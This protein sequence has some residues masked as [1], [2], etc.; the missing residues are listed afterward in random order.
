MTMRRS[1]Q[2]AVVLVI[3][4]AAV[5]VSAQ[6]RIPAGPPAN[7]PTFDV[8][9]IKRVTD[10]RDRRSVGEQPGGRFVLSGMAIAPAIR[11]A[12]PADISELI[13]A[14]DWV[15]SETYDLTAQAGREVPKEQMEAMLRAML[16]DKFKLEV[17]YEIQE[18]PVYALVLA[19]ADG[20]LG[21]DIKKS[22]L[23]CDA[24]QAA[25]RAG[26]KETYPVTSN[27]APACGMS[28]LGDQGMTM[29]LG[30]R[31]LSILAASLGSGT[32]RVVVDKTGLKGNY[33]VRLRFVDRPSPNA[34]PDAPPEIFTALQEQL[35]LK[36]EPDRAP[37]KVLVID[38]I[39]KPSEN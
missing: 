21:P 35:G 17:H 4:V 3:A 18:R 23:D 39:E 25:R 30:A 10:I 12:Y 14:P 13:G 5:T 26:S 36:L 27:G 37:L 20:R 31:P 15:S 29:L 16:A 7:G 38:R 22:E 34:L 1:E 11:S 28:M 24:I 6:E 2:M 19:R 33:D 8:V 9:S 32:G